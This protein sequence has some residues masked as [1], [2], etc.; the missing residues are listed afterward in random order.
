MSVLAAALSSWTLFGYAVA[1]HLWQSTVFAGVAALLTL[2]LRKNHARTRYW[3]WLAASL[4][5]L[6]PFVLL[7]AG[8]SRLQWKQTPA[9]QSQVSIVM[10][11]ITQ[12]FAPAGAQHAPLVP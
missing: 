4:K 8:G 5:F 2:L 11:Q 7:V 10:D 9:P 3:L 6:L 1:N 12:P